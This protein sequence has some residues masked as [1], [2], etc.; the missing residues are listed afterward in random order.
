MAK[1]KPSP[2]D[3]PTPP[4][5]P[6]PVRYKH[7]RVTLRYAGEDVI[8]A[9][10]RDAAWELFKRKRGILKS[11]WTPE[12]TEVPADGRDRQP[13]PGQAPGQ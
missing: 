6:L 2:L 10:D 11:D 8:E 3:G 9:F 5:L 4:E 1:S 13:D 7:W 12:I